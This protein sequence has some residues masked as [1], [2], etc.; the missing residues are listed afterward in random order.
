MSDSTVVKGFF[1]LITSNIF[2]II[3]AFAL[4][5]VYLSVSVFVMLKKQSLRLNDA[6]DNLIKGFTDAPD[7]DSALRLHE[8][9]ESSLRFITNKIKMDEF[10]KLYLYAYEGKRIDF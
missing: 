1:D 10:E 6:T 8:K 5:E 3:Y 9:I 7:K 4:V 2:L